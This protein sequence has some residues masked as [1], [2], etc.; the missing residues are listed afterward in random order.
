M[1]DENL[2]AYLLYL[3]AGMV[4]F[5]LIRVW[6]IPTIEAKL[7]NVTRETDMNREKIHSINNTLFH[8]ET[9]IQL[10]EKSEKEDPKS[11]PASSGSSR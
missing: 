3:V 2:I 11:P 6:K 9:R 1:S 7:D 4:A 10:L 5:V 8:H